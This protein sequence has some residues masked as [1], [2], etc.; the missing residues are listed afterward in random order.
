MKKIFNFTK[1]RKGSPSA[2]DAGSSLSIAYDLKEKDLGKVHKA[3]STGDV[4]KLKQLAKK[5]DLNQLDKENRTALHIACA[6]GHTDVVQFLVE[7]KVKLNLCDNQNRSA[8]MKAVQC[9][10]DRC[11]ALLL[12]H[13][14]DPN[15]VDINGNTAL[16][17]AALIPS[18]A[19]ALLLLD[20]EANINAQNKEGATP[21]TLAVEENHAE[22]VELFL[23]EGADVNTK[24]QEQRSPLMIAA[25]NGQIS[26][27]RLLLQY[28]ADIT[29]K[30]DKGWSSDDYAVMNGHHAC[31]HLIIEHG[32]KRKSLQSPSHSV[33]DK[34]K[35]MSMLSSHTGG[36]DAGFAIAGPALDKDEPGAETKEAGKEREDSSPTNSISRAS[37][38]DAADSWLSSDDE[39]DSSPKKPRKV[40]LKN[41][42]SGS[43]MEERKAVVDP[44]KSWSG[45]DTE[46]DSEE[47]AMKLPSLTKTPHLNASNLLHQ[48][49]PSPASFSKSPQMTSAPFSSSQQLPLGNKLKGNTLKTESLEK[50]ESEDEYDN[51]DDEGSD[52]D[53]DDIEDENEDEEDEE[54]EENREEDFAHSGDEAEENKDKSFVEGTEAKDLAKNTTMKS[55]YAVEGKTCVLSDTNEPP[56]QMKEGDESIIELPTCEVKTLSNDFP[57]KV[58][59]NLEELGIESFEKVSSLENPA[60]TEHHTVPQH[61]IYDI[62]FPRT[63]NIE[64]DC[65]VSAIRVESRFSDEDE[66]DDQVSDFNMSVPVESKTSLYPGNVSNQLI[67]HDENGDDEDWDDNSDA[68]DAEKLLEVEPKDAN[69]NALNSSDIL[70]TPVLVEPSPAGADQT[71]DADSTEEKNGR[72][73]KD[74]DSD[75]EI[76]KINSVSP[77]S[78]PPLR[79]QKSPVDFGD[80]KDE[81]KEQKEAMEEK[82]LDCEEESDKLGET[83][84]PLFPQLQISQTTPADTFLGESDDNS[85]T[86]SDDKK[87][88]K[89]LGESEKTSNL[90]LALRR[91][92]EVDSPVDSWGDGSWGDEVSKRSSPEME[93]QDKQRLDKMPPC[94]KKN[95]ISDELKAEN[96][97]SSESS[98]SELHEPQ[99]FSSPTHEENSEDTVKV[100]NLE[101]INLPV[102]TNAGHCDDPYDVSD[103]FGQQHEHVVAEEQHMSDREEASDNSDSLIHEMQYDFASETGENDDEKLSDSETENEMPSQKGSFMASP[104]HSAFP[105][106]KHSTNK[107]LSDEEEVPWTVIDDVDLTDPSENVFHHTLASD[108]EK[109]KDSPNEED[110]DGDENDEEIEQEDN[111]QTEHGEKSDIGINSSAPNIVVSKDE[112]RDFLSELGL[113]KGDDEEDSNWD[114]ESASDNSGT[115]QVDGPNSSSKSQNGISRDDDDDDEDDDDDDEDN[116]VEEAEMIHRKPVSVLCKMVKSTT[117]ADKKTDLMEELGLGDV[118][119]LED[120]SDWD[121]NST[122]SKTGPVHKLE[123][124]L[125]SENPV[126]P[127]VHEQEPDTPSLGP[128]RSPIPERREPT[129]S[130]TPPLPSPRYLTPQSCVPPHPQPRTNNPF[131]RPSNEEESDFDTD[132]TA[133]SNL[134]KSTNPPPDMA[135]TEAVSRSDTLPDKS[136]MGERENNCSVEEEKHSEQEALDAAELN[137]SNTGCFGSLELHAHGT[138]DKDED[139]WDVDDNKEE[140]LKETLWKRCER[141]WVDKEKKQLNTDYKNVATELKEK[142]GEVDHMEQEK[143]IDDEEQK[144]EQGRM[145]I[146]EKVE[147]SHS[148]VEEE[149]SEEDEG[150]PIVRPIARARS[151]VLL[152][153]PE[154]RESGPED[155]LGTDVSETGK[156]NLCQSAATDQNSQV[157]SSEPT[158]NFQ[159][160]ETVEHERGN[161][162]PSSD[163]SEDYFSALSKTKANTGF[164][165]ES[166]PKSKV[167]SLED[168]EKLNEKEPLLSVEIV[169]SQLGVAPLSPLDEPEEKLQRFTHESGEQKETSMK[170]ESASSAFWNVFEPSAEV[171]LD[172]EKGRKDDTSHGNPNPN[173]Q[174]KD[175]T[176]LL[177]REEN[178]NRRDNVAKMQQ[179][180]NPKSIDRIT[181]HEE[182]EEEEGKAVGSQ[183]IPLIPALKQD[184]STRHVIHLNGDLISVFDDSS[185]SEVS[186]E[187]RRSP[188][189]GPRSK[190]LEADKEL[191]VAEDFDDLTQSSDTAT[192]ELDNPVSGYHHASLLIKQLDSCSID[193]VSM[194][195]LQNMFHE[196]ERTIHRE[197]SRYSRLVDK[198]AQLEQERNELKLLLEETRDGKSNLEHFRVE[199][200]I[201]LNNLKFVL[202][203]EQEKHKSTSM[204]YEKTREQLKRKEAQHRAESEERQKVELSRR[205]MEL[206]MRALVNNIKQLEADRSELQRLLAHERNARALQEE[207]LSSHLR[208]QQDIEEE[209]LKNLNKSN[210]AVPQLTEASDREKELIQ[211]SHA[212]QEEVTSLRAELERIRSSARQ[213]E[214][215]ILEERDTLQERLEDAR[216]D[217][218]LSEEA[219]TQT[220]FQYNNQLTTLKAECSVAT[221]KLEHERQAHQQLEAE[222]ETL[223]TRLQAALQEA[224]KC[225]VER[226]EAERALQRERSEHQWVQ[227]KHVA[228]TNTQRNA[229]QSLSQKLGKAEARTNSLE[230]ECHH[231]SMA[232]VE[233]GVLIETLTRE[234]EQA[235]ARVK[236]LEGVLQNEREQATR[237]NARQEA[238][239]ERLAQ[240]QSETALL[241]QQLEE[242]QNKGSAKDKAVTDVQERFSDILAKLR[243]DGEERIQLVEERS[244]E[245]AAKNAELRECN[246]RLEQEK[247]EREASMRQ[248]QQELADSL[249][250]LSMCEANLEVNTRYRR[251]LEEEKT[252]TLQDLERLKGKLRE[253][254]EQNMQAERKISSLRSSLDDKEREVIATSLK[255]QEALSSKEATD[256]TTKQLE[257]AIQRLEI[258][259]AR[260][261]A[262]TKQQTNRIE[263]LQ[264]G[265]QEAAVPSDSS[266]GHGVRNRLED[267]VANLQSSKMSLEDQLNQ[268]VQKQHVLSSN[269]HDSQTLWEEELKSR[270]RLGLRLS[271]LE[272]EKGELH[273][274]MEIE[275]KKVK[276]IAEQKKSVDA[277]L[278]QEMKRNSELQKEMYRL[279]TLVKTAK[280]K[281]REQ[282]GA[283]LG[284]PLTSLRGDMLY[285][286][287][288]ADGATS[289]LKSKVDEL[290]VQLDKEVLRCSKLEEVNGQLKEQLS[291]L[292]GLKSSHERM[293]KSKRQLE[294]QLW[295]M[296]R[297]L[298]AGVMD[299]SQAE[300]YR[301]QTE[302][303]ARQ[304][305]RHKL[306]EVN[307]FLQTQAASQEA[308]E[309]MKAANEASQRA[310]LE[311]RIKDLESELARLRNTQQESIGRRES[312]RTELERYRQLYADELCL[313]KS[314]AAKLDRA[315]ERLAEANTKLL[316]ERQRSK[317]LITSSIVNSSLAAP[318]LDMGSLGSVGMYGATLGP[319]NSSL[320]LG[321]PVLGSAGESHNKRVETY[322]AKMQTE[323]EKNISKELDYA[324][325]ELEGSSVRMS[326]VGSASGSQRSLN[327]ELDPVSR[328]TQQYLEVLKKNHMI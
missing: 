65:L 69:D 281:L 243:S 171:Q 54:E 314:L 8:L 276:K 109:E 287:S 159:T 45:T 300:E 62:P 15:L 312:V 28:D 215:R 1:K 297:Q 192:E 224:E 163:N 217:L 36:A 33:P 4:A 241:R 182:E 320:G 44:D 272:K 317:S 188:S 101:P 178:L 275:K 212:L 177:Q 323:L 110:E 91:K 71:N 231:M 227:D 133:T 233:K 311:Q 251:D 261:E 13:E 142:F 136:S 249:K 154:Q 260:L 84:V 19:I 226:A 10:Q 126:L 291:S 302:E 97:D 59:N 245:L 138:E 100:E 60:D 284:S 258:E 80:K 11:V 239:Q 278:D 325:A 53:E 288:E 328:A 256:Q 295:S 151:K 257:E 34:K 86:D 221:S 169:P 64:D 190:K 70:E 285:R 199:L 102:S 181:V 234:R 99:P 43:K 232:L 73:D 14:A 236:E 141:I 322:L 211:Q 103:N 267:L 120:A 115:Q 32:T 207:L 155:S 47:E 149:S 6:S 23:K 129:P 247:T 265:A 57:L 210:E 46:H 30:D 303:R 85:D 113:E 148:T 40:N 146:S 280:K 161:V 321:S 167:D 50:E 195:K 118:D 248:L 112:Q 228:E 116:E 37:K 216:R 283:E 204:L 309:Q 200:E 326:P 315:N 197:R 89:V 145:E 165:D 238:T 244:K 135:E 139:D 294:E 66:N 48:V 24:N 137:V 95:E 208:K 128:Q 164:I 203:Q 170:K 268:Q 130:K 27:V 123:E 56:L 254:E 131:Q 229:V 290:Q 2:S 292:K 189:S 209:N 185:L 125:V 184:K 174:E 93:L 87:D 49:A 38:S 191:E 75:E 308:L 183:G 41:L 168:A 9:Q 7:S 187:E 158:R 205:D 277:R 122:T 108:S 150:E 35:R 201:D 219:L 67:S 55:D 172:Q 175:G 263:A 81:G 17:L 111:E 147:D 83:D 143:K 324:T 198:N 52:E 222:V 51:N 180:G 134:E 77:A 114:S 304:E 119:D 214:A 63:L 298:E 22:M 94:T 124:E 140:D 26:M 230:N 127:A 240:A 274:L 92:G 162:E 156:E 76:Y 237:A 316:T 193:S 105:S 289:R 176:D 307:L 186:E 74:S 68:E 310:Q 194:V 173:L 179:T 250:K 42:I 202:K 144:G 301:R 318:Q 299:Q 306:E 270:S 286:Q 271:E 296:R 259:N 218:K 223:R 152:P 220:V 246:Y 282:D 225:Q 20:H 88:L 252:R 72:D 206:E 293:E 121:S 58:D 166:N 213:E 31:S 157:L 235:Q 242:A 96:D 79:D 25:C 107:E 262:A 117:E 21:L 305:I 98:S 153:I 18:P 5:N 39:L 12:E 90:V 264:K 106:P 266:P 82:H 132:N 29:A 16:H 104:K 255:L 3:A 313:R 61:P 78:G 279:R 196:Y 160:V 269:A 253:A 327:V 273:N 319:L